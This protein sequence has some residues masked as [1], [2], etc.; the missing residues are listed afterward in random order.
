MYPLRLVLQQNSGS[1][2]QGSPT[3]RPEVGE[4]GGL[5]PQLEGHMRS[6][7][8]HGDTADDTVVFG[9]V[10][11]FETS[12]QRELMDLKSRGIGKIISK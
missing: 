6:A 9:R 3:S 1:Q 5:R 2:V 8:E 4:K 7:G 12:E 11:H 10:L